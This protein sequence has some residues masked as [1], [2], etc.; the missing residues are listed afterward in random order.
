MKDEDLVGRRRGSKGT[1]N[2]SYEMAP[3]GYDGKILV[4]ILWYDYSSSEPLSYFI[5]WT[6]VDTTEILEGLASHNKGLISG[7]R[8]SIHATSIFS[9]DG[10]PKTVDLN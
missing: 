1:R 10:C 6:T 8:G 5:R 9:F 2:L 7:L 4:P 3:Q